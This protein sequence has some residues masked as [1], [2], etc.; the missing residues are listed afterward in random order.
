MKRQA[1]AAVLYGALLLCPSP[2]HARSTKEELAHL[3]ADLRFFA[4]SMGRLA[5]YSKR[6]GIENKRTLLAEVEHVWKLAGVRPDAFDQA[7]GN[8]DVDFDI[9]YYPG[10]E[11]ER[12][13]LRELQDRVN[14]LRITIM[15]SI[16]DRRR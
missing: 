16:G 7:K 8:F 5:A 4:I 12:R 11:C 15:D 9:A 3:S 14:A 10:A 1:A 13:A 6:C 2:V